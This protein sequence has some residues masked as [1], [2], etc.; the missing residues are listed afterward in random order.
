[1]VY[2]LGR[3]VHAAITTEH[4]FCG[5][6]ILPQQQK[7]YVDN[8]LCGQVQEVTTGTDQIDCNAAHGLTT[9]DPVQITMD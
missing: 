9:G 4:S 1:M 7:V 2:F 5:L 6:S 3:D 8:V